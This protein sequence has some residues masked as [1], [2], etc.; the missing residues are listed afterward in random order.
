LKQKGGTWS[1]IK[2]ETTYGGT[3]SSAHTQSLLRIEVLRQPKTLPLQRTDPASRGFFPD[4]KNRNRVIQALNTFLKYHPEKSASHSGSLTFSKLSL[5]TKGM[6]YREEKLR[7]R[8]VEKCFLFGRHRAN[9]ARGGRPWMEERTFLFTSDYGVHGKSGISNFVQGE[10]YR[11]EN[12]L[13][14]GM[15][16]GQKDNTRLSGSVK[17]S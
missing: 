5:F 15:N 3:A 4:M 2:G 16:L 14:K 12:K 10:L 7:W 9:Y 8:K 11:R 6:W 13:C 1:K 17:L